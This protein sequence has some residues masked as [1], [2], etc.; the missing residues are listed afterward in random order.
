MLIEV[1]YDTKN[2]T[3]GKPS[4]NL[5]I[6]YENINGNLERKDKQCV[7]SLE[8]EEYPCIKVLRLVWELTFLYEG[9]FYTPVKYIVDGKEKNVLDLYFLSY[10]KCGKTWRNSAAPL[11]ND[12]MDI[13]SDKLLKYDLFSNTERS[14]GKLLKPLINAFYYLHSEAYEK[15]N[16]NHRLSLLLNI[17]DGYII[18][19]RGKT[20]NVEANIKNVLGE[21][22]DVGL[23]KYGASLLGIPKG[24]LY[25]AL[26]DERNEIDH[27]ALK[28]GSVTSYVHSGNDKR[29]DYINWYFVYMI[30]L[31]LRIGLLKQIGFDVPDE[32]MIY[33]INEIND[34][35]IYECDL[36]EECKN[37]ANKM[38][39]DLKRVGLIMK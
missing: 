39:Q 17:C 31:A 3:T 20:N 6:S 22:L 38:R 27:Y 34:W 14:T 1:H 10:Y 21:N 4:Y 5:E 37:P 29:A 2:L 23:V 13:S 36:S 9:Y 26:A 16:V 8:G 19:T 35:I 11:N 24:K 15:I 18:N 25:E 32:R 28:S 30:E 33:A 7:I 12:R